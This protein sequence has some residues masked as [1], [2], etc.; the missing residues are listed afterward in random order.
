MIRLAS[1]VLCLALVAGCA[2]SA[3][4]PDAVPASLRPNPNGVNLTVLA[5]GKLFVGREVVSLEQLNAH[6]DRVQ[7]SAGTV[8]YHRQNPEQEPP[9][10]ADQVIQAII[11]RRLAVSFSTRPDFSDYVDDEGVSHPRS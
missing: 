10:I 5:N 11:A 7:A 8:W 1:L 2:P 9:P 6:L 3:S 4:A